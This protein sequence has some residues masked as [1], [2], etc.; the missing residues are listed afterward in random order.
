M[1]QFKRTNLAIN[2]ELD[3]RNQQ[4]KKYAQSRKEIESL[5]AKIEEYKNVITDIQAEHS[6]YKKDVQKQIQSLQEEL[7]KYKLSNS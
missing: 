5:Q 2:K 3:A 4:L 6:K 1:S 7:D